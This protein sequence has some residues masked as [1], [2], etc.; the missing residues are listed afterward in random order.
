M[1]SFDL[2]VWGV[3]N[4]TPDSFSDGGLFESSPLPLAS[5][6]IHGLDIGAESTNPKA[7]AI[8]VEE[9][10]ERLARFLVPQL[11]NWPA[12]LTLSLDTYK[13]ETIHWFL[14]QVPPHVDVVWND[15]S[16][17]FLEATPLLEQH[18]RL[19]YVC[20]H[21]TVPARELSG[22]HMGY[23]SEGPIIAAM[24]EFFRGAQGHF[25]AR[26]LLP[27][28]IADPCFG[29]GKTREQNLE[30]WEQ[31]PRL[32]GE[33]SFDAWMWG[34]SRKSF[35]RGPSE[36]PRDPATQKVL[37]ERQR[38]WIAN[39]LEKLTTMHT[40]I[41]RAHDPSALRSLWKSSG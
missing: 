23:V 41:L 37:D 3:I 18:P 29:F 28:V 10:Q 4:V 16:G 27:R 36:D 32:M 25:A 40:I 2:K 5:T 13:L 33:L 22:S 21:T 11:Q 19:R 15:V 38:D 35:L 24:R 7:S 30:A 1:L 14:S 26:G 8:T 34:I 17:K 31:L 6:S 39:A 20:C 9:E 12:S